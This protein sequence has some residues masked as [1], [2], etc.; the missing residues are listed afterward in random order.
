MNQTKNRNFLLFRV[1]NGPS[2]L[3][4]VTSEVKIA[5]NKSSVFFFEL[6]NSLTIFIKTLLPSLLL[7]GFVSPAKLSFT[8]YILIK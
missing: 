1:P 6:N 2:K 7:L 8:D 3:S 4:V 5:S